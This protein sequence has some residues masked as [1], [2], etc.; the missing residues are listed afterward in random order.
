MSVFPLWYAPAVPPELGAQRKLGTLKKISGAL[1]RNLCPQLQNRVGAYGIVVGFI[2][3]IINL[4]KHMETF[5]MYLYFGYFD[6][7]G[8]SV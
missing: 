2:I 6:E 5:H 8:Q 1:R 4:W 7:T 3:I